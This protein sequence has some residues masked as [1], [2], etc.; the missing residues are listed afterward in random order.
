MGIT[1]WFAAALHELPQELGDFG[2]L[3]ES[4]WTRKKALLVNCISASTFPFGGILIY[5]LSGHI[6]VSLLIPFAAGNFV[7]VAASGLIPEI[8]HHTQ[9]GHALLNFTVFS[10]GL[11][12]LYLLG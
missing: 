12:I 9:L 3:V 4:G 7:Y 1:A 11:M 10:F 8:K 5:L 6:D 2:I